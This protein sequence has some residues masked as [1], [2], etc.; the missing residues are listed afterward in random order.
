MVVVV[1]VVEFRVGSSLREKWPRMHVR[2]THLT[3]LPFLNPSRSSTFSKSG[4]RLEIIFRPTWREMI[5]YKFLDKE[6]KIPGKEMFV[7]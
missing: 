3:T 1:V 5:L 7:N 6:I 2:S 4:R